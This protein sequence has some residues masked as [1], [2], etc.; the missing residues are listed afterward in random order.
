MTNLQEL[1]ETANR[2]SRRLEDAANDEK[3]FCIDIQMRLESMSWE[4]YRAANE[5]QEIKN[6]I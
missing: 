5:L 1:I 6:Y 4:I 3:R 2:L